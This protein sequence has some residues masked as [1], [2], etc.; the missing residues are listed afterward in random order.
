MSCRSYIRENGV[1]VAVEIDQSASIDDVESELH[2]LYGVGL[3]LERWRRH[4]SRRWRAAVVRKDEQYPRS[5]ATRD[6]Q[7]TGRGWF[8]APL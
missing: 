4:G 1:L 8:E 3:R 5:H 6:N 2:R 7:N